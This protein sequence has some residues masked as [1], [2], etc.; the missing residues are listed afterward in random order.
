MRHCFGIVVGILLAAWGA[1]GAVWRVDGDNASGV[2][3]GL[4]WATAY[5]TLQ[6]AIDA[7]G[8]AG[9]GTVW[10]AEGVYGGRT[11]LDLRS[12]VHIL[13]G[14]SGSEE[15]AAKRDVEAHAS[16]LDAGGYGRAFVA[17]RIEAALLDG[18]TI[19][20]GKAGRYPD[21]YG[22]GGRITYCTG[23]RIVNCIFEE[24]ASEYGGRGRGRLD[25]G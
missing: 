4:S 10:V 19:R 2:E 23:V 11:P 8:D 25:G 15:K 24:N 7:A 22:G 14:F 16:V 1:H 12:G 20:R 17:D 9:G 21:Y 5:T 3:D 13:G 6:P 18:L